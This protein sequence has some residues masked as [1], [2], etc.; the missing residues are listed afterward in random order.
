VT[1]E[2]VG[3]PVYPGLYGPGQIYLS[4]SA[5]AIGPVGTRGNSGRDNVL[6]PGMTVYDANVVRKIHIKERVTMEF[7]MEATNVTNHPHW[8]NPSA[9]V[10]SAT[11][12]QITSASNPRQALVAGRLTF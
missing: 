4:P 10:G 12:G 8:G 1:S 6:G 11:F 3:T 7:R 9:T 5:F 2:I